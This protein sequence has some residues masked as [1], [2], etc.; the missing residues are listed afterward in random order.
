[1][2]YP[3]SVALARALAT[4]PHRPHRTTDDVLTHIAHRL[5]LTR[6]SPSAHDPL[7]VFHTHTPL[8]GSITGQT[9]AGQRRVTQ[10]QLPTVRP[11]CAH[12]PS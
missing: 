11:V 12:W 10:P 5:G 9:A 6:L 2:I 7:R 1:M 8:T 4:L 3:E